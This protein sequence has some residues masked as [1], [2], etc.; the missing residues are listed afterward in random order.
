MNKPVTIH[1]SG[2]YPQ[3]PAGS[4]I[5]LVEAGFDPK[6][7]D[8]WITAEQ[9]R[10]TPA[11]YLGAAIGD[12]LSASA[13]QFGERMDNPREAVLGAEGVVKMFEKC[14][15]NRIDHYNQ[16]KA[17]PGGVFMPAKLNGG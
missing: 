2:P 4:A 12:V 11:S 3:G 17:T 8:E 14:L 10:A 6:L 16:Y 5:R 9:V 15:Q 13:M 7:I 1:T